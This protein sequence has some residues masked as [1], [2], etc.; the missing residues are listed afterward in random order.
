MDPSRACQAWH[1]SYPNTAL[2]AGVRVDVTK[3]TYEQLDMLLV[4]TQ[5]GATKPAASEEDA[6]VTTVGCDARAAAHMTVVA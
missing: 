3:L 6:V 1:S 2:S 4:I 5:S